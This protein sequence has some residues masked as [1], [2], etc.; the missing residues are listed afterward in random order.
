MA[1]QHYSV[2]PVAEDGLPEKA[3]CIPVD[4]KSAV[5]AAEIALGEHSLCGASTESLAPWSEPSATTTLPSASLSMLPAS[6]YERGRSAAVPDHRSAMRLS[7]R[8]PRLYKGDGCAK[9]VLVADG[10]PEGISLL[11]NGRLPH[12]GDRF[13]YACDG[14][15][16]SIERPWS[17][18]E[19]FNPSPPEGLIA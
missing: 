11:S 1:L 5:Q 12:R 7:H 17:D 8:H 6:I 10:P 13:R 19:L 9:A 14:Q 2:Q 3:A 15:C 4:A 16:F 18:A